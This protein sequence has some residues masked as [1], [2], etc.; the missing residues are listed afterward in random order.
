M[1]LTDNSKYL[2][3]NDGGSHMISAFRVG[4]DGSLTRLAGVAIPV[5]ASGLAAQ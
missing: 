4:A 5:G 1:A 3:A 2:Y